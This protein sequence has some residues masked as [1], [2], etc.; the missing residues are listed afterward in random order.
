M[1]S[2]GVLLVREGLPG[3]D[4]AVLKDGSS[5]AK[6]EIDG[7]GDSAFSVELAKGVGIESVLVS[8]DAAAEEGGEI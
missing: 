2:D 1:G 6:D 8:V 3:Q 5:I 7:P 4:L